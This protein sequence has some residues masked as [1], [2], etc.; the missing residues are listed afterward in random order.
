MF[1]TVVVV[2]LATE[3]AAIY[4]RFLL[5]IICCTCLKIKY[6]P[7]RGGGGYKSVRETDVL[8]LYLPFSHL[9]RIFRKH[10]HQNP[11]CANSNFFLTKHK[12]NGTKYV[13]LYQ[14]TLSLLSLKL[15]NFN[16]R[17]SRDKFLADMTRTASLVETVF[18]FQKKII[19]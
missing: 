8:L 17:A 14:Y 18:T 4:E 2:V 13:C 7:R 10:E 16:S 9:A 19:T 3:I 5:N 11:H 1:F 12:Y 6:F 15:S